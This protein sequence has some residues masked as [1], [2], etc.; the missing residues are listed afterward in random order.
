MND[1][2]YKILGVPRT[3]LKEDIKNAYRRLAM[4]YHPDKNKGSKEAEEKFKDIA[5]AYSVLS[6]DERRKAYDQGGQ[7]KVAETGFTG[8]TSTDDILR[9]FS[10]LFSGFGMRY[11]AERREPVGGEDAR[12][13][14]SVDFRT[15]ALGGTVSLGLQGPQTCS[16]CGGSGSRITPPRL[17]STCSGT[18]RVSQSASQPDQFFSITQPCGD[19]GGT[20]IDRKNQCTHCHGRRIVDQL[21]KIEVRIPAG[22]VNGQVLRLKSMGHPGPRNTPA[23]DLLLSISVIPDSEFHRDGRDIISDLKIPFWTAALGG[24]V[25]A[26]TV[27]RNISVSVPPGTTSHQF[28]RLKGQGIKGGSHKFHVVV[29]VPKDLDV[30]EKDLLEK[31]AQNRK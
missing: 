17:C 23:G 13:A 6:D 14:V 27:H 20:G 18:G 30:R 31:I 16:T 2:Y 8:W 28:I 7:E 1:D 29:T 19:C 5:N 25:N 22:V 24:K 15:A 12:A 11:H 26:H 4:K 21:R 3:A 9:N 10:D